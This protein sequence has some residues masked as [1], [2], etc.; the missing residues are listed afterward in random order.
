MDLSLGE[1]EDDDEEKGKSAL[2]TL[3]VEGWGN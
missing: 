2:M 3:L 1:D